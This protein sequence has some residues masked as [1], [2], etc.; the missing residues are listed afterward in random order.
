MGASPA[1]N[2]YAYKVARGLHAVK[3][4]DEGIPGASLPSAYQTELTGAL[5]IR[6][7]LATVFFGFNDLRTGVSR[8]AYLQNLND[9]V[10]TLR[11]AGAKV[12]IIGLP[13]LSLLPAVHAL[14]PD[15]HS[16]IASWNGGTRAVAR[17]TGAHFLD[18]RGFDSE[19]ATHPNYIAADGLHPSNA[20]HARL[21]Q[22]VLATI[23]KDGLWQGR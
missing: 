1:T 3:F 18:L 13:D 12:L 10:V 8:K 19:I 17:K 15:L 20:G 9:L 2:G 16:I 21:A 11:R 23:R 7:A 5:P 14:F 4:R 6:P 22:V